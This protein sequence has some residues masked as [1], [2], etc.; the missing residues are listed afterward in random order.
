MDSEQD[1]SAEEPQDEAYAGVGV[2]LRTAREAEQLELSHIAAE[3]RIPL[4]HLEA[5]EAGAFSTL[6]SR[7]YAIGFS[8]TYARAVGLDEAAIADEVRLELAD[9][10]MQRLAAGS[11]ME[12]G[13]PAKLPSAPLAW[14]GAFA[15]LVL[16]VGL[17][18]FFSS[19]FGAGTGPAPL[20][21]P[22]QDAAPLVVSTA[23]EAATPAPATGGEVV[24]T[25]LDDEVW[26]RI[27][28]ESGERL[29]EKRMARDERYVLPADATDP[30]INTGRPDAL[31]I[32]VDGKSVAPLSDTP[33][34]VS[35]VP[36]SAAALLARTAPT[37]VAVPTPASTT[38]ASTAPASTASASVR[39]PAPAVRSS[40][41][42][43]V[44]AA[45]APVPAA[46]QDAA[47]PAARPAPLQIIAEPVPA[48]A[49]TTVPVTVPA[50][51][52]GAVPT[53]ASETSV[54]DSGEDNSAG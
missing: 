3:T 51:V 48:P 8:R 47:P 29:L 16:A 14:F 27:Y 49:S 39:A 50:T 35:R 43:A 11:V 6:P 45:R 21:A 25:A 33:V 5:I 42:P 22:P 30:R 10:G 31:A 38:P 32:T 28:E 26:V 54:V 20:V 19:R 23:P 1:I 2:R 24:F 37:A 40:P 12:P 52:P 34:T 9:G 41:S 17:I 46:Q 7:T 53:S 15:A 4:R 36:V 13:D 18:A 44:T